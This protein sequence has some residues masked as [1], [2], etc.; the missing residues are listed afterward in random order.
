V[1]TNQCYGTT[2]PS[3]DL[4]VRDYVIPWR[5]LCSNTRTRFVGEQISCKPQY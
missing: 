5:L 1:D 4:E 3:M 2:T